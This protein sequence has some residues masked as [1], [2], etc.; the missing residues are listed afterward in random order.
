M[1]HIEK[2]KSFN[3]V[4]ESF[5]VQLSPIIG[6]FFYSYFKKL[7]KVNCILPIEHFIYY[8]L[9]HK[10][11]ILTENEIYF[12]DTEIKK[13]YISKDTSKLNEILRLQG[14]YYKLDKESKKN[15]WSIMKAL[16]ILV[17]RESGAPNP[18]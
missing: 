8:G 12:T 17:L 3:S 14:I 18:C 11:N 10:E 6:S 4:V 16:V 1:S 13:D 15:V 7:I 2:I 5:L 9:P